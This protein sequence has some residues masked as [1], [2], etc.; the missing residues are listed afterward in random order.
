MGD[1][2]EFSF[3][4]TFEVDSDHAISRS[5]SF[6]LKKADSQRRKEKRRSKLWYEKTTNS[7][8]QSDSEASNGAQETI[9]TA[10]V[11]KNIPFSIK[12]DALL[13]TLNTLDI[14]KPYAFNYHFDNGVFRGL[15]FANY[16]TPEDTD[17]VVS[18]LNGYEVAGRKLRVE[19]K[20]VLPAAE[21]EAKEREKLEKQKADKEKVDQEPLLIKTD[22]DF[23]DKPKIDKSDNGRNDKEKRDS[24]IKSPAPDQL[25]L[26][27]PETLKFYD[28]VIIFRDDK[29]R[30]ELVFSKTLSSAH[31]R[32][33]QLIAQK[34]QLYYYNEGDGED[35]VLR[36]VRKPASAAINIKTPRNG[37]FGKRAAAQLLASSGLSE[38]PSNRSIR[39][40]ASPL[41]RSP[42]RRSWLNDGGTIVFPIRQPR[43]PDP[44]QNFAYRPT[45]LHAS[46]IP[47]AVTDDDVST[48]NFTE[49]TEN[50]SGLFDV[51]APPFQSI[52]S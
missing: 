41:S 31:R 50:R 23:L 5:N 47:F 30:E 6:K 39:G 46:A 52:A 10:I 45:R 15:A 1:D 40:D 34:L 8:A 43:G 33:L 32:T 28:Q 4:E 27:D 11:I 22:N 20:R 19:Y 42:F 49:H 13:A 16:R 24:T 21:R 9:P 29:S 36:I 14:P 37:S 26:N 17:L 38:S 35:K 51:H 48:T 25:D 44:S 7:A 18:A 2:I 12:R 3:D